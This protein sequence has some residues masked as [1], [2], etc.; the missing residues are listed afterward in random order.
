MIRSFR[1]QSIVPQ[2]VSWLC[3]GA[4]GVFAE[5]VC[6]ADDLILDTAAASAAEHSRG[7][8]GPSP[9]IVIRGNI[10]LNN[11]GRGGLLPGAPALAATP[12]VNL[13]GLFDRM[14]FVPEGPGR[15]QTATGD[16]LAASRD[17]GA[18]RIALLDQICGL[19]P[20]QHRTLQLTLASDL[21]DFAAVY[22]TARGKYGDTDMPVR[23]GAVDR[24]LVA[25]LQADAAACR[26]Q[27][28]RLFGTGSL[29]GG[30]QQ[31]LLD[32]EQA[33]RLTTWVADRRAEQWR[34]MVEEVLLD[35][36]A[37]R[38]WRSPRA[39]ADAV[40]MM[41]DDVPHLAVFEV[42]CDPEAA[43]R[44]VKFQRILVHLRLGRIDEQTLQGL[45]DPG[46]WGRLRH[47]IDQTTAQGIDYVEQQ[48]IARRILEEPRP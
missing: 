40:G 22:E 33:A 13:G 38:F 37:R 32:S 1:P 11:L 3:V 9:A 41:A 2:F 4:G 21:A 6:G 45:A 7:L 43:A 30:V 14:V 24:E 5:L 15:Q 46:Q 35:E 36:D 34:T 25:A 27:W 17:R 47:E 18:A 10:R 8:A 48:L 26:T 31:E 29:L 42:A 39:A 20:L 28:Q 19:S 12:T 44:L 16:G 23:P